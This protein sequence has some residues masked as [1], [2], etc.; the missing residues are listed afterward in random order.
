MITV[1]E[2]TYPTLMK[3]IYGILILATQIILFY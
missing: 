3:Y 1:N 2:P